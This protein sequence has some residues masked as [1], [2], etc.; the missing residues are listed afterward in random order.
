MRSASVAVLR[1]DLA[2]SEAF[3]AL[4][5]E[6]SVITTPAWQAGLMSSPLT[7]RE[8]FLLPLAV[9]L[10]LFVYVHVA[11][12]VLPRTIRNRLVATVT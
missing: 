8:I 7:F 10:L 12:R 5:M 6:F 1:S 9:L 11:V 4:R 2:C 3:L